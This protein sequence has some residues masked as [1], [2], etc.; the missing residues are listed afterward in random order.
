MGESSVTIL[1]D[2]ENPVEL[3][4]FLSENIPENMAQKKQEVLDKVEAIRRA[5]GD[6]VQVKVFRSQSLHDQVWTKAVDQYGLTPRPTVGAGASGPREIQV[7]F[8]A[9]VSGG[10]ETQLVPFFDAVVS[11]EYQL[12]RA[13][14]TLQKGLS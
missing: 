8:G 7:L 4:V 6:Q 3:A 2:L 11:V 10:P 12:L 14:D 13:I 9:A 5:A 1:Q